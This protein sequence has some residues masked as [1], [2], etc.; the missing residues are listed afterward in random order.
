MISTVEVVDIPHRKL[1][2]IGRICSPISAV[3]KVD[4]TMVA[5]SQ[6]FFLLFKAYYLKN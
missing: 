1:L 6:T 5:L 3:A 4:S 2:K